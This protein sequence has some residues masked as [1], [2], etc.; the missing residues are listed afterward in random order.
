MASA[1]S[2]G[3]GNVASAPEP[4]GTGSTFKSLK[5]ARAVPKG[6]LAY[7][8]GEAFLLHVFWQAPSVKAAH[9]L[10]AGLRQCASAT[11]RDTP[12]VPTYFFRVSSMGDGLFPG[13]PRTVGEHP[14]LRDARKKR[15][16]GVPLPAVQAHLTRLGVDV[17]LLDADESAELP[18]SMRAEA[19]VL[20]FTEVYL[21][22]RSFMLHAVSPD[23]LEGYGAVMNPANF[24][25]PPK[26]LRAGTPPAHIV[27]KILE[28]MLREQVVPMVDGCSLWRAPGAAASGAAIF[29]SLDVPA[30]AATA[31]DGAAAAVAAAI[32]DG[33]KACATTLLAF[34]HPMREHTVRVMCVLPAL[35]PPAD[36][37]GLAALRPVRG[38]A[39]MPGADGAQ[40]DDARTALAEAG[41]GLLAVNATDSAGYALHP[42]AAELECKV[43][44]DGAM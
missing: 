23:Y 14:H 32:P 40:L 42:R 6:E 39:H 7:E 22:A 18:A 27:D 5:E 29:L 9:D 25:H 17:A 35:P 21:D 28:P 36:L 12:C 26:T 24:A 41:L 1:A 10:L 33:L 30:P 19:V 3:A 44:V 37:A 20:E 13:A 31:D 16:M 15:A 34:A 2:S 4:K 8:G 38:E 43:A 11:S